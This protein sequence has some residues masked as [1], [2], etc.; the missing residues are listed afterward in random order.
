MKHTTLINTL[1][2]GML[3]VS[4]AFA[5]PWDGNPEMESSV[6]NEL[7]KPAYVGTSLAAAR[8]QVDPF[9]GAFA[10]IQD[11]DQSG[12]VIGRTGP[13]KGHGDNYGWVVLDASR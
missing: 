2:G 13:E 6:L 11:I 9:N 7:D 4:P 10:G 8:M 12:F 1:A 3:I 5:G